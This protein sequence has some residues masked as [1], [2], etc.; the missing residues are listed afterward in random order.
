MVLRIKLTVFR[1]ADFALCLVLAGRFP[2]GVLSQ[3]LAAIITLV[4]FVIVCTL[5]DYII[6]DITFVVFVCIDAILG[7]RMAGV[8]LTDS[9]VGLFIAVLRPSAPVVVQ[10]I[11]GEEGRLIRRALGAQTADC[12]GLV[13]DCLFGTGCSRLQILRLCFFGSEAVCRHLAVF[14]AADRADSLGGAGGGTAGTGLSL[15]VGSVAL[16]GAGM[17][18]IFVGHPSAPVVVQRIAGEEGRLIRR[19]LGAQTADCAGLVVDCLFR[20]GGGGFQVLCIHGLRREVVGQLF[21]ILSLAKLTDGILG[22]GRFAAGVLRVAFLSRVIR[23]IAVFIVTF[24]PVM[25]CIGR[26]IGLPAMARSWNRL[27][28]CCVALGAAICLFARFC[29]GRR[30]CYRTAVPSMRAY[31]ILCIATG[32]LLPVLVIIMCPT[33]SKIM[34]Q[35]IAIFR[36]ANCACCSLGAGRCAAV[37]ILGFRMAGVTLT[38]SGVGLFIAVLRP[39][40][41][42]V[43]KRF[44]RSASFRA[45]P[46]A[47]ASRRSAPIV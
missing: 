6:A 43:P 30:C 28:F 3:L 8:T 33:G 24:I 23:H 7:F 40:A 25:R 35:S 26:P 1:T 36:T 38:D 39:S 16:A 37:A 22:A 44:G 2:A 12:A 18:A 21:A 31:V 11:A 27:Y 19:A 29:A 42:V 46:S 45:C 10:H 47:C 13:I 9:G 32:T 4:V 34:S 14:A 17:G 41:P 5:A 20:A 15:G